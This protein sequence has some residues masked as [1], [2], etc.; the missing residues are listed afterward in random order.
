MCQVLYVKSC[1]DLTEILVLQTPFSS[2]KS[3]RARFTAYKWLCYNE[4][5]DDTLGSSFYSH[6]FFIFRL[7]HPT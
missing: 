2:I 4:S 1:L 6:L 5:E 7:F 3:V